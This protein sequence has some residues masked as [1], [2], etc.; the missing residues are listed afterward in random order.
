[1]RETSLL[2]RAVIGAMSSGWRRTRSLNVYIQGFSDDLDLLLHDEVTP[3]WPCVQRSGSCDSNFCHIKPRLESG[4][5]FVSFCENMWPKHLIDYTIR[6]D[7]LQILGC[8]PIVHRWKPCYL[9]KCATHLSSRACSP[10]IT[11]WLGRLVCRKPPVLKKGIAGVESS[12]AK[13]ALP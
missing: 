4:S 5:I 8:K 1:M 9:L 2:L 3:L 11:L 13:H 10:N 12:G 7:S 6:Y